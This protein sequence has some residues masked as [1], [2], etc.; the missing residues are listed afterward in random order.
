MW[1]QTAS[2][3]K[4]GM[5]SFP[6]FPA[7]GTITSLDI[8]LN[9]KKRGLYLPWWA[10]HGEKELYDKFVK[11]QT[12]KPKRLV[13]PGEWLLKIIKENK[14]RGFKGPRDLS[15]NLDKYLYGK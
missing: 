1:L 3:L 10:T 8:N 5:K 14:K 13:S 4:E 2:K 7:G 11:S 12:R 6:Y 15:T 9:I